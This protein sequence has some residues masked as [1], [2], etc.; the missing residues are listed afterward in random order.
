M[1][2][3]TGM[4][5]SR[6][7]PILSVVKGGPQER[8]AYLTEAVDTIERYTRTARTFIKNKEQFHGDHDQEI[9]PFA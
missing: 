5:D 9:L 6:P 7:S 3:P 1:R 8:K 4:S 2:I